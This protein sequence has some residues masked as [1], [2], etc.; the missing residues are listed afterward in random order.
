LALLARLADEPVLEPEAVVAGTTD[1]LALVRGAIERGDVEAV[2][3]ALRRLFVRFTIAEAREGIDAAEL[4]GREAPDMA[5]RAQLRATERKAGWSV[6]EANNAAMEEAAGQGADP[7]PGT[8][9]AEDVLAVGGLVLI[10][11]PRAE[12]LA[13]IGEDGLRAFDRQTLPVSSTRLTGLTS[14]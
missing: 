6:A 10:P 7:Q 4:P 11:E 3:G 9:S 8:V 13:A 5:L 14:R 2:R 12:A 1:A